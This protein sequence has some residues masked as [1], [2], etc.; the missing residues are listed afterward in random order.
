MPD[1]VNQ[2]ATSVLALLRLFQTFYDRSF[3][4]DK[5]LPESGGS[6]LLQQ[7]VV[8]GEIYAGFRGKREWI[9]VAGRPF[10]QHRHQQSNVFLVTDK[11]VIDN[12]DLATPANPQQ[13]VQLGDNLLIA[14]RPRH[15]AVNFYDVAELTIEGTAARVLHRHVAVLAEFGQGEIRNRRQRK[16]WPFRSLVHGFR[17]A[18]LKVFEEPGKRR[19]DFADENV[20]GF[21]RIVEA[22]RSIG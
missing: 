6:H 17:F 10:G 12:E 2:I 11:I 8:V 9:L 3:D 21:Y 14:L 22:H 1:R 4:A 20:I 18:T 19:L 15:P 5:D 7:L 16:G 13:F